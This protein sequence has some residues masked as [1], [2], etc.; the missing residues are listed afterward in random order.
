MCTIVTLLHKK[1]KKW[2]RFAILVVLEMIFDQVRSQFYMVAV[3]DAMCRTIDVLHVQM[4]I[5]AVNRLLL[6]TK[7]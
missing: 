3:F 6:R 1:I 2:A 7:T 4:R 5:L